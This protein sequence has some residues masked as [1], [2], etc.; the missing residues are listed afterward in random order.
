MLRQIILLRV[1]SCSVGLLL[2]RLGRATA[3]GLPASSNRFSF[4]RL[5][6]TTILKSLQEFEQLPTI[7][8]SLNQSCYTTYNNLQQLT[9][10]F[11]S[12]QQSSTAYNSLSSLTKFLKLVLTSLVLSNNTISDIRPC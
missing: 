6:L 10:I 3:H 12:L 8:N 2:A 4:L 5:Q 1:L 11:N 7:L 9:T